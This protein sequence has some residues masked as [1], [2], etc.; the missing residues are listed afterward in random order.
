MIAEAGNKI[1]PDFIKVRSDFPILSRK[2][3]AYPLVYLDNAATSQ[4]PQVVIDTIN[5]YYTSYN[6]NIHRGAHYLANLATAKYE[7]VREYIAR[8]L[9]ADTS[10]II[11]TSGT[12]D[13]L[14]LLAGILG[15]AV[16]KKGD[17]IILS[18]MEHHSNIV[19][20]QMMAERTGAIIKVI[21]VLEDGNLDIDVYSKLLNERTKLVSVVHISNALGT[22]NPVKQMAAKAHQYGALFVL[23][24]AQSAAHLPLDV[25]DLDCDFMAFS[26][27][28]I[29][30]PTGTGVL[31]GKSVLLEQ[32]PPYR[33]GG[34][35]IDRVS[36]SGTTYNKLP[37]KYEAGTP[38]I[39]G[40][41][42]F[43]AALRYIDQFEAESL[44]AHEKQLHQ[45]MEQELNKIEGLRIIGNAAEKS[46]LTSFIVEDIH[47]FDI[48]S[49]LDQMGIAVRTGHHCTQPLMERFGLI[50]TVRASIAFYNNEEDIMQFIGALNKSLKMLRG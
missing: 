25:N 5:D 42:A 6:S 50:G 41:I 20:W 13:A 23:D 32:L 16:I 29:C 49:L 48:G 7:E 26:A 34:E 11:F 9:N 4:K 45:L 19:P 8:R 17:E 43:G 47:P 10:E 15:N 38:D 35:M 2:V 44:Y 40:V 22:V 27:H 12:T 3:N 1:K 36:F 21:P 28:K 46:S 33:G 18:T 24:A 37:Y 14:N 30:G 31:F 39:A